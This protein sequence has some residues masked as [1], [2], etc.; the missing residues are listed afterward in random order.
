MIMEVGYEE[1][2]DLMG[3]ILKDDY[4]FKRS[5]EVKPGLIVDLDE[6]NKIVVIEILDVSKE[7]GVSK[8]TVKEAEVSPIVECYDYCCRVGARFFLRNGAVKEIYGGMFL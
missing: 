1:K 7:L 2:Y 6:D 8:K 4:E 5:E 3:I